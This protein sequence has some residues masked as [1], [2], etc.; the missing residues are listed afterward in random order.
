MVLVVE[1][2][3]EYFEFGL[4]LAAAGVD[5]VHVVVL[6]QLVLLLLDLLLLGLAAAFPSAQFGLDLAFLGLVLLESGD[7]VGEGVVLV[8]LGWLVVLVLLRIFP[9][10]LVALE[11]FVVAVDFLPFALGVGPPMPLRHAAF[12]FRHKSYRLYVQLISRI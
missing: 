2:G 4:G 12:V 10:L 8:L 11:L 7:A 1:F 9:F 6:G 5:V 3:V